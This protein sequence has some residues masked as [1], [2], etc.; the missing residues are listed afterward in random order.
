VLVSDRTSAATGKVPLSITLER[1]PQM[2]PV[3]DEGVESSNTPR[4]VDV[5]GCSCSGSSV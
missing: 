2:L 5:V 1:S 4:N 3:L